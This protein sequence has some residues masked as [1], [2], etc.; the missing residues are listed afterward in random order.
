M[1]YQP[2]KEDIEAVFNRLRSIPA[3][4]ACFDCNA[5]NPTWASVTYGVFICIDCSAVHRGL[6]V[7]L[8]FVRSTQ[9]DT[10]WTL[11]QLRQ[12][13]LGGNSNALQFFSQ[14]N[15]NTNDAQKKY[16][17]RAAQLYR[18]KLSQAAANSLK[19]TTQSTPLKSS[20]FF[21]EENKQLHVHP[22]P[23]QKSE[24]KEADFFSQHENFKHQESSLQSQS[25]VDQSQVEYIKPAA[26]L[27]PGE[28]PS[29]DFLMASNTPVEPRKSAITARKPAAKKSSLGAK[30]TG[31][32]ATKVKTN[33]AELEREAELAEEQRAKAAEEAFKI[34]ALTAKEQEEKEATMR[35]VYKDIG[36]QQQKKEEQLRREDPKK[37][38][39]LERLGM[40]IGARTGVSHSAI[41]DMQT[42][43][44]ENI[45]STSST[46]TS[47]GKL[48]LVDNDNF[49]E[50]YLYGNGLNMNRNSNSYGILVSSQF[51]LDER[52]KSKNNKDSWVIIDDPPEKPKPSSYE[53]D[54][55]RDRILDKPTSHIATSSS[56]SDEA[57]KKFGNAKAISSDQF[58]NDNSSEYEAKANLSR[59]Q[60]SS[61]IS[62]AEFFGNGKDNTHPSSHVQMYDIDDVKESV[63]QGVTKVAGKLGSMANDLMSSLQER[64]GY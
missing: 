17:S 54:R 36:V 45:Q 5:K 9:L 62:S 34:A 3:N 61:S 32:G 41:N 27:N 47:L 7:H 40:G 14:H 46:L 59:F 63:R 48:R 21:L 44:Q 56:S 12:M 30:K 57:Q 20:A 64:Y 4:K 16:N 43:E 31:L 60:G 53:N 19:T 42:I 23:Q 22:Q 10:N 26:Q 2:T 28:G 38:E 8:T 51:D 13:Q 33:F 18:E 15:C 29:V 1:D 58:F 25:N 24:E 35:L 52:T 39:Q 49:M 6:G 11:L 37:A 55:D 50:D